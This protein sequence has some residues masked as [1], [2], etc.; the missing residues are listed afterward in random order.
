M[1]EGA[2]ANV[3][4]QPGYIY[5]LTGDLGCSRNISIRG[6]FPKGVTKEEIDAELDKLVRGIDRQLCKAVIAALEKDLA[7]HQRQLDKAV[8]DLAAMREISKGHKA[9]PAVEVTRQDN[10]VATIEELEAI[11]AQKKQFLAETKANAV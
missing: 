11:V 6:N 8:R 10:Q 9:L 5:E 1:F 3:G 2:K 7:Q 4:E